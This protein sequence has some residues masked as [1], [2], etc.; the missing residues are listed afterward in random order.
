MELVNFEVLKW[1]Y[2]EGMSLVVVL[3][4][5]YYIRD[6]DKAFKMLIEEN[7]KAFQNNSLITGQ[8]SEALREHSAT[9]KVLLYGIRRKK[10]RAN[11]LTDTEAHT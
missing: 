2:R 11:G 3:L 1:A 7:T 10:S 9:L 6:R 4:L 8:V 5:I